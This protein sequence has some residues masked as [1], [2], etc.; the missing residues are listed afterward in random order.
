M[1][2]SAGF[3]A[4][5]A[6][7]SVVYGLGGMANQAVAILLVPIYAR[8]LGAEGV[9]IAGVLNSTISLSRMCVGLAPVRVRRG[10]RSPGAARRRR[11]LRVG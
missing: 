9:G 8:Q 1:T 2:R 5:L 6:S 11:R 10:G 4:R 7:D 3:G